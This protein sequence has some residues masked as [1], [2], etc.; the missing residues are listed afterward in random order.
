M[1]PSPESLPTR[2]FDSDHMDLEVKAFFESLSTISCPVVD[3][4]T[5]SLVA[6]VVT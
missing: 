6:V 2:V 5:I 4:A 1:D 3:K